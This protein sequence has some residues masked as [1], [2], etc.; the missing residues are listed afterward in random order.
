[1]YLIIHS[2]IRNHI[3]I[4]GGSWS[5]CMIGANKSP[6]QDVA[7]LQFKSRVAFK[8]VWSPPTFDTVMRNYCY[9]RVEKHLSPVS[10]LPSSTRSDCMLYLCCFTQFVLVDDAG[11]ML[12]EGHPTGELPSLN[13]RRR[14]YQV[15]TSHY[16]E[17]KLTSLLD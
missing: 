8:L 16:H 10:C 11:A 6:P 1:M 4:V 7:D 2:N 13:E 15:S 17:I 9:H 14:N 3:M 5:T 12:A